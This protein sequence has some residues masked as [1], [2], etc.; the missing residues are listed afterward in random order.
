MTT[1]FLPETRQAIIGLVGD[2]LCLKDAAR[3]AGVRE[4]TLKG[5]LTRGRKEDSGSYREF[6]DAIDVAR[7]EVEAREKP[8]TRDELKLVVSRAAKNG[9]VAAQKLY[10][11][12][13][14]RGASTPPETPSD[15]FAELDAEGES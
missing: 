3:A 1:K 11:E 10:W 14:H 15:P 12:M 2:G 5:W 8:M 4:K 9:S 6:A 7:R 13:L